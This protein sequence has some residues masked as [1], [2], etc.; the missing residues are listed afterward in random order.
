MSS[1]KENWGA[2]ISLASQIKSCDEIGLV[3]PSLA[4]C[5]ISIDSMAS[6]ARSLDKPKV[7]RKDFIDWVDRYLQGHPEQK[8]IYRGKDVYAARCAFLHTYGATSKIHEQ[9][10]STIKFVYHD[11]GRHSY[12][13]EVDPSLVVI[14]VRS[15]TNDVIC[16]MEKFMEDCSLDTGLRQRVISRLDELF[17]ILPID[18]RVDTTQLT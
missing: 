6:L 5:F 10:S 13:S 8:Y 2:I 16:A 14:G 4:M 9:D 1:V 15:F 3:C 12:N 17:N 7:T 11:G 18:Q